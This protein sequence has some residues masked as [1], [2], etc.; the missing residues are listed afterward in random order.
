MDLRVSLASKS[1][2]NDRHSMSHSPLSEHEK[3]LLEQLEKQFKEDD[4]TFAKAMEQVPAPNRSV[5]HMVAGTATAVAGL[6][7]L[8][9]GATL[10]GPVANILVGVL[11]FAVMILGALLA[12]RHTAAIKTEAPAASSEKGEAAG[13]QRAGKV[14]R[15]FKDAFGDW[16]LW[17]LFWWV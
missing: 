17:S 3:S 4:P 11:G 15:P 8:L 6:L 16:A 12:V 14:R 13:N 9:L 2:P 5:L 10:Q 7:L 1:L